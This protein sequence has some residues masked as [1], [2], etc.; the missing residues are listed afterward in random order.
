MKIVFTTLLIHFHYTFFMKYYFNKSCAYIT[1]YKVQNDLTSGYGMKN[2]N[3]TT[4]KKK[5]NE[6]YLEIKTP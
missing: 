4:T 1:L 3:L 6:T 2:S 5:I